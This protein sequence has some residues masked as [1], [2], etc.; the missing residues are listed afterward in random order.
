MAEI[1]IK[2]FS[3]LQLLTRIGFRCESPTLVDV[4][5]HIGGFSKP[6]AER[7]WRVV[8]FEPEPQNY[9]RLCADLENLPNVT[10]IS[11]AVSDASE[12]QVAFYV[13]SD[14][15]GIHSLQPFHPVPTP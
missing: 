13:S 12:Q 11:E 4:G 9:E 8:A 1:G 3:E 6:F 7:G 14:H 2:R 15:W 5:A 10:C